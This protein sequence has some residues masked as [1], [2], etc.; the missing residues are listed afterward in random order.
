MDAFMSENPGITTAGETAPFED[1]FVRLATQVV[2]GNPPDLVQMD[3]RY[4]AE[5]ADRGA[6]REHDPYLGNVLDLS[7]IPTDQIDA[8]RVGGKLYGVSLG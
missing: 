1:F 3:F 4:I 7:D 5:Y 6:L 2:G 8:N